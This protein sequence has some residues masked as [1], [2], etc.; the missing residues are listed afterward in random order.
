M[1]WCGR[2]GHEP[3]ECSKG[4]FRVLLG[5]I[6]WP[7]RVAPRLHNSSAMAHLPF[8]TAK[9]NGVFGGA[10]GGEDDWLIR[11]ALTSAP[12]LYNSV[13][14]WVVWSSADD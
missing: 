7:D 13:M 5:F 2:R 11:M 9:S 8:F 1:G 4:H 3:A 6:F 12:N 10:E 14:I